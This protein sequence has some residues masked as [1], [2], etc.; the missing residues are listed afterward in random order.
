M[1]TD[2]DGTAGPDVDGSALSFATVPLPTM[3]PPTEPGWY[4]IN[5]ARGTVQLVEVVLYPGTNHLMAFSTE[6]GWCEMRNPFLAWRS[7]VE[8]P[9]GA[10]GWS[11]IS[12]STEDAMPK[13]KP[14]EIPPE[15]IEVEQ[16][17]PGAVEPD[18]PE[19]APAEPAT[20]EPGA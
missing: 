5:R 18:A 11:G 12:S 6:M 13:P 17:E 19:P 1:H 9:A 2:T 14:Q 10:A 8:L 20:N 7:K 15:E 4:V 16:E 3:P